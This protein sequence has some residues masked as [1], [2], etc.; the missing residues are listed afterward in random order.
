MSV[1]LSRISFE[2]HR[3][4]LGIGEAEPRVSWRFE[5]NVANWEQTSYD[6]EIQRDSDGIPSI[7]NVHS[8][9]SI[10]VPWP[11]RP[12]ESSE[13]ARVRVKAHGRE[14]QPSTDWS[15][16]S[17]VEAG[18]LNTSDWGEAVPIAAIRGTEVDGPKRPVYFRNDF[19]I[20]G[21]VSSARLYITALGLYD[22]EINGKRVGDHVLAPG[23]Q[24]YNYRHVYDTYDVTELITS[25][26]NAIGVS[27][28]EGWY[29]GR[30]GFRGED[31][32]LYGDCSRYSLSLQMTGKNMLFALVTTGA[33]LWDQS[34]C[35]R[36]TT[37]KNTT[38]DLNST[39]G[40]R[41]LAL[42][43]VSG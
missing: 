27:V 5:G 28:G 15:D 23:W 33:L 35:L 22:A 24:S 26:D 18:L 38:L 20:D 17:S 16:W 4:A 11:D 42:T 36:S 30:L 34:S 3:E 29:A 39:R 8:A 10:Y 13:S 25:G 32:N 6:L 41:P 43:I 2:H 40:G 12:L 19:S 9:D 1:S 14:G 7:Y 21:N 31:R 37:V